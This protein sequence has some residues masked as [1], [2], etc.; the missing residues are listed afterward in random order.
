MNIHQFCADLAIERLT[1]RVSSRSAKVLD[2]GCGAGQ[3]VELLQRASPTIAAYGCDIFYDGGSYRRN[4]DEAL[5]SAGVFGR[6]GM[7]RSPSETRNSTW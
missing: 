6:C 7:G 2:Y 3:I 5:L 4:V 1:Q